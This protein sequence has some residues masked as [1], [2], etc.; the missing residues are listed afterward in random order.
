[1]AEKENMKAEENENISPV[2]EDIPDR[3]IEASEEKPLGSSVESEEYDLEQKNFPHSELEEKLN[4]ETAV[5]VHYSF[6]GEDVKEGLKAFQRYTILKKNVVYSLILA[7]VT[8]VYVANYIN[9]PENNFSMFMSIFC[10]A[11]IGLLWFLPK[12]HIKDISKAID[13]LEMEYDME[14]Y[15]ECVR[16]IE[17]KG[18]FIMV[19]GDEITLILE[20]ENLFVICIGKQRAF[21]LP[22]RYLEK[23]NEEKIRAIFKEAMKE[24][25]KEHFEEKDEK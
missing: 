11:I 25:Y 3:D 22:K 24:N 10:V 23:E 5:K 6:K 15:P 12:K 2:E 19:Y 4:P 7:I 8:A 13:E 21:I 20:T 14:V 17:D 9:E 16:I 18:K 1:M